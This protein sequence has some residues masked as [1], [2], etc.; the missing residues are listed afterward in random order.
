MQREAVND[1]WDLPK[2]STME[3]FYESQPEWSDSSPLGDDFHWKW[4][5][6]F[7][8]VGDETAADLAGE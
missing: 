3:Q 8:Q 2:S 1:A 4:Y 6:A 5:Y 7:Q